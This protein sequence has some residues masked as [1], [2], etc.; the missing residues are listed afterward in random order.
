LRL[1]SFTQPKHGQTGVV[2]D[3]LVYLPDNGFFGTDD[4]T[5]TVTDGQ[6]ICSTAP[7]TVKIPVATEVSPVPPIRRSATLPATL[8]ETGPANIGW[9][10]LAGVLLV[11]LGGALLAVSRRGNPRVAAVAVREPAID[12]VTSECRRGDRNR[13][14]LGACLSALP[15]RRVSPMRRYVVPLV[16]LFA[17]SGLVAATTPAHAATTVQ[18]RVVDSVTHAGVGGVVVTARDVVHHGVVFARTTTGPMGYFTL[19]GV[20]EEEIGLAFN[21][22]SVS[23]EVGWLACNHS[24]VPTWGQACSTSPGVIGGVRLDHT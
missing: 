17:L 14:R 11:G 22:S 5:Y 10:A 3:Q 8:P 15:R 1:W 23:Y 18:G 13:G 2:G 20:T 21:G 16:L 19:T 4:F 9:L 12:N 24:V 7:V 6:G